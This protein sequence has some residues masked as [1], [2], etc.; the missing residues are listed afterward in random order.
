MS[1]RGHKQPEFDNQSQLNLFSELPAPEVPEVKQPVFQPPV[2]IRRPINVQKEIDD[3]S[4][5]LLDAQ[6]IHTSRAI[7]QRIG[8]TALTAEDIEQQEVK[9]IRK[10]AKPS[11]RPKKDRRQLGPRQKNIADGDARVKTEYGLY[12]Q[13]PYQQ[14]V[15]QVTRV[16]TRS[17]LE[18][19]ERDID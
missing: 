19:S 5:D 18:R 12:D 15:R 3:R 11:G 17:I 14:S 6:G 2:G 16:V 13:D 1:Q 4:Y 10:S 8:K 7:R 9:N